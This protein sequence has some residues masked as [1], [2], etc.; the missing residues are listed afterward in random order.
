MS[1]KGRQDVKCSFGTQRGTGNDNPSKKKGGRGRK[2]NLYE[3]IS[4]A[5]NA[6]ANAK[7]C[8]SAARVCANEAR[9]TFERTTSLRPSVEESLAS[10]GVVSGKRGQSARDVAKAAAA[11]AAADRDETAASSSSG[12]GDDDAGADADADADD[13]E[14]PT[15]EI[16]GVAGPPG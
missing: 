14:V 16:A 12:D 13:E 9:S 7:P 5:V 15:G 3:P 2:R 11:A 6:A 1:G 10:A 8:S 4:S